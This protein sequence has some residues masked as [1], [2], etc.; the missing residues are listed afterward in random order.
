MLDCLT[1]SYVLQMLGLMG[2]LLSLGLCLSAF[3]DAG[4]SALL[5][6]VFVVVFSL[7]REISLPTTTSVRE[8]KA[9]NLSL[10]S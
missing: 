5:V 3:I 1:L 7:L 2:C 4:N 9:L 6:G 10:I 8:T